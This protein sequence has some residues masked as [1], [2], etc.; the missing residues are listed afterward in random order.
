MNIRGNSGLHSLKIQGIV[1]RTTGISHPKYALIRGSGH[2]G[3][4][5]RAGVI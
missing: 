4:T 5:R 3:S 1:A 2:R